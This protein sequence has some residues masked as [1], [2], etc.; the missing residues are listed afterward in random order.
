MQSMPNW[1]QATLRKH[2]K[3]GRDVKGRQQLEEGAT[4]DEFWDA[5]QQQLR[6]TGELH[7]NVRM[8]WGEWRA[9][10]LVCCIWGMF[11]MSE[12]GAVHVG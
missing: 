6:N 5:A 12:E 10:A 8:T 7:N 2:G 9:L 11:G 4:G 3:D 1:A